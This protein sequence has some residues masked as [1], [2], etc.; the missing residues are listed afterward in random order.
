MKKF[1]L[2][3]FIFNTPFFFS[4]E[5]V[6]AWPFGR[7]VTSMLYATF[8]K[9]CQEAMKIEEVRFCITNGILIIV[10]IAGVFFLTKAIEKVL[11]KFGI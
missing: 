11:E 4:T 6:A 9:L 10:V 8:R 7:K 3:C 5:C 2:W 1:L